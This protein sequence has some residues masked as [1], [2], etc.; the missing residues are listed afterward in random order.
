MQSDRARIFDIRRFSTHDGSGIRTTVFF[1]GCPLE[2]VWCHNPEG[3]AF[4]RQPLW[5]ESKCVGCGSCL[6]TARCGGVLKENGRI[7]L[8][9][10][11]AEDWNAI[12]DE[13]P[14]GAL[15]WD[16]RE[17]SQDEVMAEIRKDKPFYAHG[18]GGVTL[19]GGDP[20]MQ[21]DFAA[22]LLK[23]CRREGVNTAIE[24]EL[25]APW[26][27]AWQVLEQCD[28]IYADLKLYDAKMHR[29]Y[30]GRDNALILNNFAKLLKSELKTR[31]IVRLPLIPQI[32]ATMENIGAISRFLTDLYPA[33]ALEL[34]NYNPL[35]SA[36]YALVGKKYSLCERHGRFSAEEMEQFCAIAAANGIKRLV[37]GE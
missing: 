30:T 35:A 21:A 11:C 18:G 3:I 29:Q 25:Y 13:C 24:T 12:V 27:K 17:V 20:L 31:L 28:A 34:L 1:K 32:T 22:E 19:S 9:P 36:K 23:N 6:R 16:S 5:F 4:E 14:A 2:C 7:V 33:T 8:H 15:R 10:S 37:K 26:P